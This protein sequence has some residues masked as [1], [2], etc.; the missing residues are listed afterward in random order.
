MKVAN[1]KMI[2]LA[3]ESRGLLRKELSDLL[4]MSASNITR[5]ENGDISIDR[6]TITKISNILN[7]PPSFFYQNEEQFNPDLGFYRKRK[8]ICQRQLRKGEAM[9]DIDR[10]IVD[11][12]IDGAELTHSNLL[13]WDCETMG[14]PKIAAQHL[15]SMWKVPKGRIDNLSKLVD[16][17]GIIVILKDFPSEK[18]DGY[19]MYTKRNSQPII[20]VNRNFPIDRIRLTIAHELGHLVLHKNKII[21]EGRDAEKEAF[22]FASEF[23]VPEREF[24]TYLDGKVDIQQ[25]ITQKRYWRIS[26]HAL[27]MHC[28]RVGYISYNQARYLYMQLAPHRKVEPYELP[29]DIETPF[30]YKMVIDAYLEDWTFSDLAKFLH[31]SVEDFKEKY[32]QSGTASNMKVIINS[33]KREARTA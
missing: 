25:L 11:R 1:Y 13:D 19:S 14:S 16:E 12:L 30:L 9:I 26:M 32:F 21:Y 23:L 7:Y 15:R 33:D 6:S 27:V 24:L 4:G 29:R 31:L 17:N 8:S 18:M 22:E 20:F 10:I 3:R 2:T 5:I 28:Q